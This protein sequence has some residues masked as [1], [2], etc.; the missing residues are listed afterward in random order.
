MAN[1]PP[2]YFQGEIRDDFYIEPMMKCAWAA[3]IEVLEVVAEICNR[4]NIQYFA[5]YGTLLGAVRHKGFIPWDDDLDIGMLRDDYNKFLQIAPA[6]LSSFFELKSL[7]NDPEHDNVKARIITGRSMNFSKEYLDK[8]HNCPYVVGIDIFPIDYIPG[9]PGRPSAY[10]FSAIAR[11]AW[12]PRPAAG[13]I[14][15]ALRRPGRSW[16][17][18]R[19]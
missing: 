2:N 11:P 8:F 4:H 19:A 13:R 16:R 10:R 18:M 17:P 1:F 5:D 9:R 12:R 7:Y 14:G 3:E 15:S 6:E